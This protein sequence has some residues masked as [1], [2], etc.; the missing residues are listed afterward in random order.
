MLPF[1]F[2]LLDPKELRWLTSGGWSMAIL[3]KGSGLG[4]AGGQSIFSK[5][6]QL[7]LKRVSN[8]SKMYIPT[9][10]ARYGGFSMNKKTK[11]NQYMSFWKVSISTTKLASP[12]AQA[13]VFNSLKFLSTYWNW[14]GDCEN[15]LIQARNGRRFSTY[16]VL[17]FFGASI[18]SNN[19]FSMIDLA[20]ILLQQ[21]YICQIMVGK[22]IKKWW[23]DCSF[24]SI[25]NYTNMS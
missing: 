4:S 1:A 7:N 19:I 23:A 6:A 5:H 14:G 16:K 20:G 18:R 9:S 2:G 24:C 12:W 10:E 3:L 15:D 8:P 22:L 13:T 17:T 11:G 25:C 21:D